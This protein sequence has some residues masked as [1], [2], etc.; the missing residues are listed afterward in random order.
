MRADKKTGAKRQVWKPV[1]AVAENGDMVLVEGKW[2]DAFVDEATGV[3]WE[4]DNGVHDDQL[5]TV[6]GAF[7]KLTRRPAIFV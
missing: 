6:A 5:D 1:V 2:N 3:E 7:G 4:G